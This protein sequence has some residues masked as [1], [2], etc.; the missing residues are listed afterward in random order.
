MAS[1]VAKSFDAPDEVRTPDRTKVEV[2]DLAGV[3]QPG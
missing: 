3:R 1:V 2:V